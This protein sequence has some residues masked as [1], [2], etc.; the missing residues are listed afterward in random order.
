M[1]RPLGLPGI[2][3]AIAA[4]GASAIPSPAHAFCRTT[5]TGRQPSFDQCAT[6]GVP[7]AWPSPCTSLSLDPTLVPEGWT[8]DALHGEI[9][10]A[11]DRWNNT[12]CPSTADAGAPRFTVVRYVDCPDG[13]RFTRGRDHSNT[14]SF[15]P[16]WADSP[17]FP[18]GVIAATV[19]SFDV[20][21]GEIL[22]TD[23]AFNQRSTGNPGGFVFVDAPS[24][25]PDARDFSAVLSHEL[26]H[27]VGLAH[28]DDHSALMFANY[29]HSAP[30]R[31]LRPDD[32]AAAC[33]VYPPG[34][35]SGT[36]APERGHRC[37][38]GCHCSIV[39]GPSH[40]HTPLVWA[41]VALSATRCARS[42]RRRARES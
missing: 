2:F 3:A 22:D 30:R 42:L 17:S 38:P 36:C 26:G 18:P 20:N 37:S 25:D 21:T 6:E 11:L 13:V 40:A 16:V 27:V 28:S 1:G 19:V 8:L 5:T 41:L 4:L 14:L 33:T 35:G 12:Q 34:T 7:L 10:T 39:N 15:R 29:D 24:T 32:V 9:Q 23:I 31:D